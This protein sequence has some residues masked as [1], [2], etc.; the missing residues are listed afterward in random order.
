MKQEDKLQILWAI[1]FI[2]SGVVFF[3]AFW[4]TPIIG[5]F[6]ALGYIILY[7]ALA[8]GFLIVFRSLETLN[9]EVI[10]SLKAR[11]KEIEEMKKSIEKKYLKKKIDAETFKKLMQ[12]Y[13][14]KLTEIEVKIKNLKRI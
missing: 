1:S 14:E 13:E 12:D 4:F 3:L 2:I 9:V 7:V 11:K 6:A 8:F 5:W 10:S